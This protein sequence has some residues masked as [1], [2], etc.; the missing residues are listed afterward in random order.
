M[1]AASGVVLFPLWT[2]GCPA[3]TPKG[4]TTGPIKSG[5]SMPVPK[6]KP[7]DWNAIEFNKKRGNSGAIPKEYLSAINAGGGEMAIG[8]HLP[9]IPQENAPDGHVVIAFGKR[10]AGYPQHPASSDHWFDW[11]H[12]AKSGSDKGMMSKFPAWP[13]TEEQR[14]QLYVVAGGYDISDI[15]ME[16]GKLTVYLAKLPDDVKGGDI[17]RITGHCTKH[18][19]YVNFDEYVY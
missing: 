1:A 4:P 16:K 3:E 15:G 8:K 2:A 19:E 10:S 17:L 12:V 13:G 6:A 5:A 18:G 11:I 9:Y 14:K 7:G